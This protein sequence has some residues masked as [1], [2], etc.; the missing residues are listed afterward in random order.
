M[1]SDGSDEM[2]ESDGKMRLGRGLVGAEV[3][4][5]GNRRE[6]EQ[7]TLIGGELRD[8]PVVTGGKPR[9]PVVTVVA[10][11]KVQEKQVAYL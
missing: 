4:E 11:S 5:N 7:P 8:Q 3:L 9:D 6:G 1:R 10:E 2:Y